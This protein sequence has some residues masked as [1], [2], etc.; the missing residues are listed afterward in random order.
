MN[1]DEENAAVEKV[2]ERL[3]DRFPEVDPDVVEK[4]VDEE[5]HNLDGNPIRDFVPVLVEHEA[6]DRIRSEFANA[7]DG[8]LYV[9][10]GLEP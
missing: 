1:A 8:T 7:S 10:P 3:E 5:H 9:P 6:R 2:V 4:V